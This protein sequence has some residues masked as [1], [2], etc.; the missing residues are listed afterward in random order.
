VIGMPTFWFKPWLK[1]F[2]GLAGLLLAIS[3][4]AVPVQAADFYA[5][6]QINM[7]VGSAVGGG[8]DTYARLVARHWPKHIPG[9]P[10]IIVQNMPAAGS[11][12][13]MN[14]LANTAPRDGTTIGA[15]QNHIGVEPIMGVTGPIESMRFDGR[16]M[17]WLGSATKEIPVVAAWSNS[18]IKTFRDTFEREMLVGSSGTATAD[19]VYPRILNAIIGTKFRVVAGYKSNNELIVAAER[20]ETMGRAGWFVSGMLATQGQQIA[21]GK[22]ILL[23]QLS[24][25]KHPELPNVPLITE[26][27]T[28]K[29][30]RDQ[31]AFSLSWLAM[32]RPFV[33]PPGVPAERVKLLR[34]SFMQT[35]ADPAFLAEAKSLRLDVIPMSG[36]DAQALTAR[37][38]ETPRSIIDPVRA[39]MVAK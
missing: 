36:E 3:L 38:Y 18:P 37:L 5:G 2:P 39:I 23:V 35:M 9:N 32:G 29:A 13:A 22:I 31:I 14:A 1:P 12:A 34:D 7:I 26:F 16:T 8:Y 4:T 33:A 6:K 24:W 15:V 21:E 28:D 27:V 11:L 19:T 25:E 30:K 10:P 20:G 17:N